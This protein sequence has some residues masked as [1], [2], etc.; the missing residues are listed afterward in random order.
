MYLSEKKLLQQFK[1][2]FKYISENLFISLLCNI[3]VFIYIHV[4]SI[5]ILKYYVCICIHTYIHTYIHSLL[6]LF[7]DSIF[8]NHAVTK[9][10][11]YSQN[12]YSGIFM[13]ITHMSIVLKILRRPAGVNKIPFCLVYKQGPFLKSV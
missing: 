6:S 5:F 4:T 13:I 9:I 1:H 12:Q 11:L 8:V 7:G 2:T 10:H 3:Y